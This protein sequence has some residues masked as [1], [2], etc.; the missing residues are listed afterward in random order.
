LTDEVKISYQLKNF[1][2]EENKTNTDKDEEF[3]ASSNL[4]Q[5]FE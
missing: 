4:K 2:E 5:I 3:E 1:T